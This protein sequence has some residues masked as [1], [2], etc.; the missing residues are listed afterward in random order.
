MSLMKLCFVSLTQP[1]S[2]QIKK[3]CL[4]VKTWSMTCLWMALRNENGK[5]THLTVKRKTKA[6]ASRSGLNAR[7]NVTTRFVCP[8]FLT[9]ERA[10]GWEEL[11]GERFALLLWPWLVSGCKRLAETCTI[12][13]PALTFPRE[14]RCFSRDTRRTYT[15]FCLNNKLLFIDRHQSKKLCKLISQSAFWMST[16]YLYIGA[17]ERKPFYWLCKYISFYIHSPVHM[18]LDETLKTA[19]CWLSLH[20]S[21]L[22]LNTGAPQGCVLSPAAFVLIHPWLKKYAFLK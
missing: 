20:S 22:A 11:S 16:V 19:H 2:C 12:I 13:A 7:L 8:Y 18:D 21:V 3:M 4:A 14:N 5:D 9:R 1:Y 17:I 10:Q 6:G 15:F